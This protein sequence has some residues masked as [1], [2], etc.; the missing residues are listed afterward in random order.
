VQAED[1]VEEG[2]NLGVDNPGVENP[3]VVPPMVD[4]HQEEIPVDNVKQVTKHNQFASAEAA[5][6]ARAQMENIA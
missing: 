4:H 2:E 3:G 6:C 1:I 5:G